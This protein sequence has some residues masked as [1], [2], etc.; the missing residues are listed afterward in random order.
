MTLILIGIPSENI[1]N[2]GKYEVQLEYQTARVKAF[3][4]VDYESYEFTITA[5]PLSRCIG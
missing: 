5:I 3:W 1:S 4:A 2:G